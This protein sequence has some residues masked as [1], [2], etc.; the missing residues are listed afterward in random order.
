MLLD[1][2]VSCESQVSSCD[3]HWVEFLAQGEDG[4]VFYE[5]LCLDLPISD[6]SRFAPLLGSKGTLEEALDVRQGC[7]EAELVAQS[8]LKTLFKLKL[9]EVQVRGL[10]QSELH[11]PERLSLCRLISA[12]FHARRPG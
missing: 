5:V 12:S 2:T 3:V 4:C 7:L 9:R 6:G 8:K 10:S 11:Q 1:H